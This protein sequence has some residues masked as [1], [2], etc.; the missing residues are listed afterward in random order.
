MMVELFRVEHD[1]HVSAGA[2]GELWD[3]VHTSSETAIREAQELRMELQPYT[4]WLLDHG[5]RVPGFAQ[6][7][8]DDNADVDVAELIRRGFH[9]VPDAITKQII[10]G[11]KS[12]LFGRPRRS[13]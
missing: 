4:K 8:R 11:H 2:A 12:R 7:F 6:G 9:R 3:K 1:F 5:S 10:Y 13:R